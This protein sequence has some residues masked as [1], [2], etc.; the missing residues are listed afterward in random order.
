MSGR[1]VIV[2]IMVWARYHVGMDYFITHTWLISIC[3]PSSALA[4][5][6]SDIGVFFASEKVKCR[7]RI[8]VLKVSVSISSEPAAY[9]FHKRGFGYPM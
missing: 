5:F 1:A 8:G 7:K 2:N 6:I 3:S 9:T 4:R